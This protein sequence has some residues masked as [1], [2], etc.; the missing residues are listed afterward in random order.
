M[1]CPAC[2]AATMDEAKFCQQCGQPLTALPASSE[3]APAERMREAVTQQPA[4]NGD[5][6]LWSGGF[7]PR[8]MIGAWIATA[9]LTIALFIV[10]FL[11]SQ[12]WLAIL[13]VMVVAWLYQFAVLVYRRMSVSY[14][15]TSQRFVIESGL[16]RRVTD[17]LELLDIEDITAEQGLVERFIGVGTIRVASS[18]RSHPELRLSGIENVQEVAKIF[19]DARL[20]ER[21]RRG[22]IISN[23]PGPLPSE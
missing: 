6:E 22:I 18:D 1:H 13:G 20:T 9:A 15:L 5:H 7:S 12:W 14:Q 23:Q 16:L 2:G 11:F 4:G 21:R 10:L 3:P 17:R 19:D 8:A